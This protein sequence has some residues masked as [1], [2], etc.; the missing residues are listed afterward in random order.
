[1]HFRNG[2]LKLGR[3]TWYACL[4]LMTCMGASAKSSRMRNI[5]K[6]HGLFLSK[7]SLKIQ[8]YRSLF[9]ATT[10]AV[11]VACINPTHTP[12]GSSDPLLASPSTLAPSLHTLSSSFLAA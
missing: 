10:A 6:M 2:L 4:L 5:L 1:M 9:S 11:S 7:G 12:A 8:L 3:K